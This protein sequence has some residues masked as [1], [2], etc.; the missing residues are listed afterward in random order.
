MQVVSGRKVLLLLQLFGPG[1][2]MN[3]A[4]PRHG[5]ELLQS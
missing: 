2:E 1:Y 3:T 5:S 4:S